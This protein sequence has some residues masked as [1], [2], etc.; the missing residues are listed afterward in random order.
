MIKGCACLYDKMTQPFSY[1]IACFCEKRD[2][3]VLFECD[4]TSQ[5]LV[6]IERLGNLLFATCRTG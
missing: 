4:D 2:A 3:L 5:G 1:V 6:H